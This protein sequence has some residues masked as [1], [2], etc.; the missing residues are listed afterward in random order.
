MI[1]YTIGHSNH[2]PEKFLELLEASNIEVLA[3]IRS[4]PNSRWAVFA[5]RD[6]LPT[7]LKQTHIKYLY[8]GDLLGG[9]P[10][11]EE[12]ISGTKGKVDYN[13]IRKEPFYQKGIQRLFEG[14]KK[15]RVCLMCSEEDPSSCH[16]NLLVAE[17]LRKLGVKV[18]HIRGGGKIQTD[19]ELWK[20]QT[21]VPTN[22]SLLPL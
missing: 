7:Y 11:E 10:E 19:E 15:Y 1:I 14:I 5:N 12:Y 16:R 2:T 6:N 8:L 17:S 18:F 3:D 20:E 21:G 9:H 13:L 22:Q 4:N